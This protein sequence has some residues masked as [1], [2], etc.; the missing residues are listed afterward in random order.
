[1]KRALTHWEWGAIVAVTLFLADRI[2]KWWVLSV[3]DLNI[4]KSV[5]VFSFFNLTMVW[6]Q[7][8]SFGLFQA[9]SIWGRVILVLFALAVSGFLI[10]WLLEADRR[11]QAIFLG[12]I[13]GGALGNALDRVLYGA[14]ADFLDFSGLRFPLLGDLSF[15]WVFNFADIGIS[16][17]AAL[18]VLETFFAKEDAEEE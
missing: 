15:V 13:I 17:G 4:Y 11:L 1:M 6:N 14:V 9:G 5:E 7:G 2:S 8:V 16:L 18:L 3:L 10:K 12:M